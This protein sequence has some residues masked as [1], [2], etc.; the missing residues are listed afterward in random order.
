MMM[1]ILY[2]VCTMQWFSFSWTDDAS[3]SRRDGHET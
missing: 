2:D 3:Q 1:M